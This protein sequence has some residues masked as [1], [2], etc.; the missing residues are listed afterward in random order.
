[1]QR[2]VVSGMT[3][4]LGQELARQLLQADIE[5]L[6]ITRQ[7]ID[8]RASAA[9]A[10]KLHRFD[11]RTE[12]LCAWFEQVR[13]DTV[14][15]LAGLYRRE[16]QAA[17]VAPL[18]EANIRFGA[19]LLE[20]MRTA[21]CHRLV[22]AGSYFQHFDTQTHR[23]LNLYAATKQA[24]E[25][26]VGYHVDAFELS[27]VRLT[28]CDIYSERDT[29]RK[30][31]PDMAAAWADAREMEMRDEEVWL[32][33]VHAEDA[34]AAFLSAAT[35][36]ESGVIPARRLS[37]YS[38]SSGR[39]VAASELVALF[40][41]L[42]G[43]TLAVKRVKGR[44][45]LR[46]MRPWRGALLPGWTPRVSIEEGIERILAHHRAAQHRFSPATRRKQ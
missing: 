4:H 41:R 27:A 12:S 16:H 32:D 33:L 39:D 31:L 37:C 45:E 14:F 34:A 30:L 3:G 38:V 24:F 20:A 42:S 18:V 23:A 43:K 7:E 2:V 29:R 8:P 36:L 13:P 44:V 26:L 6:G 10:V 9:G 46:K 40:G 28:L 25:E 5:V 15:H 1:M 21:R 11:G 19:Q 22:T 35:L 17:D